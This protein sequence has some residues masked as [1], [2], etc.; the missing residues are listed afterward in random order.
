MT[1][2]IIIAN[3]RV[4]EIE[5][6]LEVAKRELAETIARY[7][8]GRGTTAASKPPRAVRTRKTRPEAN[9]GPAN[10]HSETPNADRVYAA[11]SG[12]G[13][14]GTTVPHIAEETGLEPAAIRSAIQ[15]LARQDKLTKLDRGV[16]AAIFEDAPAYENGAAEAVAE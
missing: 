4:K 5:N 6:M 2:P 3:D 14:A 16:Y 8:E 7:P 11:I 15:S 1:H 12:H 10:G 9:S 13:S